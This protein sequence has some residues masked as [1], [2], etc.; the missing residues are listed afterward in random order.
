MRMDHDSEAG[1]G[2][3]VAARSTSDNPVAETIIRVEDLGKQ[4]TSPEGPLTILDALHFNIFKGESVA[5]VG[6]SGSGKS[7]LLGLLAGL[8]APTQGRV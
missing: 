5:V 3:N 4:V 8:D 2:V 1:S 6:A 7:T